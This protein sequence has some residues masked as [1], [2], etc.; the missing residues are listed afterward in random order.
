MIHVRFSILHIE[1]V[2]YHRFRF[3][4]YF[5][6]AAAFALSP[7]PTF[8]G[9]EKMR[10]VVLIAIAPLCVA[11]CTGASP[12]GSGDSVQL[13]PGEPHV[14]RPTG[15]YDNTVNSLCGGFMGGGP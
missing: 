1:I 12:N 11:A 5:G 13:L 6:R 9:V 4:C 3:N 15:P 8:K 10:S 14:T 2:N 7:A